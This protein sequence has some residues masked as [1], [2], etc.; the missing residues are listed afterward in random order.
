MPALKRILKPLS[1]TPF[2]PQYLVFRDR[3]RL[4][5]LLADH[6]HGHVLDIGCGDRWVAS[7]IA[8]GADYIGL[9]YPRTIELGY[10][11]KADVFADGMQL[12]FSDASFDT[13][14]I[15]DVLEHLPAASTAISEARRVL[16][17]G[18]TLILQVPFLYPLHDEPFDFTRWTK[19]G[20]KRI[21]LDQGFELH[22]L[23]CSG[24][25]LE[26]ATAMSTIAMA[27]SI[28]DSFRKP[29]LAILLAPLLL[30]AIPLANILGA[31]CSQ[32]LPRSE[33]MPLS[34]RLIGRKL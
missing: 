10:D 1:N 32:L 11:G 8:A 20:L 6:A 15:L 18:G 31:V 27:K 34:Y 17:P 14:V 28:L 30:A 13:V 26:T 4:R 23:A 21:V 5:K 25:P 22:E 12:P 19:H 33:F 16:R 9:D 29:S 2:H 3:P 24:T 7:V